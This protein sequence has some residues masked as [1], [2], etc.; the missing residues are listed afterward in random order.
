MRR[1]EPR[2]GGSVYELASNGK[3]ETPGGDSGHYRS[4]AVL[5]SGAAATQRTILNESWIAAESGCV[6]WTGARLQPDDARCWV[7]AGSVGGCRP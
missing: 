4:G 3:H 5:L 1:R 2:E 6:R 7:V